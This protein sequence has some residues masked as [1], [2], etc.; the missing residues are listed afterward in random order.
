MVY[1]KELGER[2]ARH[3]VR[4]W[5]INT[6]W[7]GGPYGVGKRM[8][9]PYTRLMVK[10]ALTGALNGGSF[11]ADPV[12]KVDVPTAVPGVPSDVLRARETWADKSAY[13]AKAR[14]LAAKF[15]E[16]FKRFADDA[17]PEIKAAA[18]VVGRA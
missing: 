6:G 8:K 1:A 18:P 16:N 5:L 14:E 10:A 3:D 11:V 4:C 15:A 13:D 2:L 7:S 9:L 17:T 12:F